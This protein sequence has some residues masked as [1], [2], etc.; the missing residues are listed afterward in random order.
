MHETTFLQDLAIVM[1]VAALAT[2]IFRQVGQPVVLGYIL[3][4]V[5]IG[6]HSAIRAHR[7]EH[8][9]TLAELGIIS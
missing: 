7:D 8:N 1:S 4:G 2:L 3:A 9:Q 5:V 6:P